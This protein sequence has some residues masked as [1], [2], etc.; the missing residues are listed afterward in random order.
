MIENST[1]EQAPIRAELE[2]HFCRLRDIATLARDTELS[3]MAGYA[4]GYAE[5]ALKHGD[6]EAARKQR[7]WLA[8][9]AGKYPLSPASAAHEG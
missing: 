9:E 7:D 6:L 5:A 2:E 1:N 8:Y 4:Y 3:R